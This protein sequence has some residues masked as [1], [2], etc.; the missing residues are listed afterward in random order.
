MRP[1]WLPNLRSPLT[2]LPALGAA[3]AFALFFWKRRSWGRSLLFA[4]A[5]YLVM[6]LPVLGFVWM[7]LMQETPAADWWQYMA[8]PGIFACVAAGVVTASRKW[9]FVT[10]LVAAAVA[11]LMIQTWRRASIYESMETYCRAVTAE[12]PHAWTLEN[13]LGI[14]LK[15]QGLYPESEACYHQALADNPGY[16]EAHINLGN[17][18]GAAGDPGAEEAEFRRAG[19]MRPGDPIILAEMANLGQ[20]LAGQGRYG[21]AEG[22]FRDAAA[23]A[24]ESIPVRIELCQVLVAQGKRDA[25]LQVCSEVDQIAR[26]SGDPAAMDAAAKLRRHCEAPGDGR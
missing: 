3:A 22:C 21:E 14:V 11:L 16:V 24:P 5:Y 12:D 1:P 9:R 7:T 10:P 4:Y 8:A 26:K 23:F 6:L 13:N 17:A 19:Q 15:R 20:M 25:A 18:L 2:Y